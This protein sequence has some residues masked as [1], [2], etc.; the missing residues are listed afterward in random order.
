MVQDNLDIYYFYWYDITY[1]QL[2]STSK[3]NCTDVKQ[4]CDVDEFQINK[5]VVNENIPHSIHLLEFRIFTR[6]RVTFQP[7]TS[8][9]CDE[10]NIR[11]INDTEQMKEINSRS[12]RG[13]TMGALKNGK[14]NIYTKPTVSKNN[15]SRGC[16]RSDLNLCY[17]IECV[18]RLR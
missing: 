17:S 12:N 11:K 14:R 10:G 18:H 15:C 8:L 1:L 6:T 5:Q 9:T 2:V 4:L 13:S 3:L 7:P 16:Y